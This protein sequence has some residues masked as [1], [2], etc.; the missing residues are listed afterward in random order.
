[1]KHTVV[2]HSKLIEIEQFFYVERLGVECLPTC[3]NFHCGTC[4]VVGKDFTIK[5]E[6]EMKLIEDRIIR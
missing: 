5:K 1:M 4:P 6:R 2:N 3:G